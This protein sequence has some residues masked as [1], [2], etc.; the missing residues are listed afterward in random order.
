MERARERFE[1]ELEA[2]RDA[3]VRA[4]AAQA[5]EQLRFVGLGRADQPSIGG[6]E[7]DRSK[8]VDRQAEPAL[9]PSDAAAEGQP[10]DAGMPD[11]PDR[12]DEPMLGAGDVE[13]AEERATAG[14]G[15]A[16]G[17]IDGDLV[18]PGEVDHDPAVAR[19]VAERAVPAATDRDLE[20]ALAPEPDGRDDI[21]DA[22]RPD[23]DG[24]PAI[25]DRVPDPASI[26][27][28]GIARGDDVAGEPAPELVELCAGGR[29]ALRGRHGVRLPR[30]SPP[31]PLARADRAPSLP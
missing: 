8:V 11:H 23:D 4:G 7:L 13:R 3:E 14:A 9:E 1:L 17:R 21:V 19:R 12:A 2:R 10:G 22:G 28:C 29:C 15:Q 5:P 30:F 20:V 31:M 24:R 26:V 25:E 16:G 6:H 27:V 18:E